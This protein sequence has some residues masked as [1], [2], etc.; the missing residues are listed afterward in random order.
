MNKYFALITGIVIYAYNFCFKGGATLVNFFEKMLCAV[1]FNG[2][3]N[4]SK[5]STFLERE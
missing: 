4:V 1:T 2:K 5:K 3:S